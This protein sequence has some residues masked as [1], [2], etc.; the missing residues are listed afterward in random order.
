MRRKQLRFL[1]TSL[2]QGIYSLSPTIGFPALWDD[3]FP[4][5][6][7]QSESGVCYFEPKASYLI[8]TYYYEFSQTHFPGLQ[9]Y[10]HLSTLLLLFLGFLQF[11]HLRKKSQ[12]PTMMPSSVLDTAVQAVN[13]TRLL[14][15]GTIEG[16]RR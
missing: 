6:I 3:T 8:H 16:G 15:S 2:N 11:F 14:F 5:C 4:Y 10:P 9:T 7:S 12:V 13:D 1:R